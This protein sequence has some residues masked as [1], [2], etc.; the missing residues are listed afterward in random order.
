MNIISNVYRFVSKL[1]T[2]LADVFYPQRCIMCNSPVNIGSTC[3]LCASCRDE[4][5]NYGKV[6]RDS[7]KY[8]E[9]AVCALEYSGHVKSAMTDFKF[10]NNRYLH[11]TFARAIY[12]KVHSRDFIHDISI[13]CPVPIH[14]MRDREYNQ[15]ELVARHLSELLGKDFCHDLLIKI[16]NITPL[17]KTGYRLRKHR[18]KSAVTFNIQYNIVGKTICLI[19]DIY[20]TGATA[21]ECSR[22]LRMYGAKKVYVLSAC[23]ATDKKQGG[24]E[25]AD[26]DITT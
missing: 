10:R 15:S 11:R 17:S 14:P 6:V 26:T 21:N 13:I 24:D 25:N 9:E 18:I 22:I 7:D 8:F 2:V 3:S 1:P 20:T 23:Y 16:K 19:D 4:L 12:Q 5:P